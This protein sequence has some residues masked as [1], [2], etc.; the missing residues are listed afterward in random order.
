[1]ADQAIIENLKKFDEVTTIDLQNTFLPLTNRE[2]KEQLNI[3]LEEWYRQIES[4]KVHEDVPEIIRSEF[5][6]TRNLAV[7]SWFC[8]S[9][10]QVCKTKAFSTLEFA[11]MKKYNSDLEF[12]G[13]SDLQKLLEKAVNDGL[14][15]GSDVLLKELPDLICKFRNDIRRGS[16]ALLNNS[17]FIL[18]TC[19]ELINQVYSKQI[20][21]SQHTI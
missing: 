9:F 14:L 20:Q 13:K 3:S 21:H 10:H 5:N 12:D 7:Y 6:V 19:S 8:H 2:T 4:I 15:K 11:L 18:K 17:L 16:N 1:M